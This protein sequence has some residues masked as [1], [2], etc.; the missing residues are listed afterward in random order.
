M[1][2]PILTLGHSLEPIILLVGTLRW[3]TESAGADVLNFIV[4]VS[5]GLLMYQYDTDIGDCGFMHPCRW[6]C[7]HRC[8]WL[9]II[10]NE[11]ICFAAND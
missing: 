8:Q 3:A 7:M 6:L 4:G 1:P 9:A 10:A 5:C 11:D 2:V